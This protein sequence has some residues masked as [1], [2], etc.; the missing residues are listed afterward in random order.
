MNDYLIV[1]NF[2]REDICKEMSRRIF[3]AGQSNQA[4]QD[5]QCPKSPSFYGLF[6]DIQTLS[7]KKIEEA[8]GEELSIT[9]NYCRFYRKGEVLEKHVDREAC[10]ISFTITLDYPISPWPIFMGEGC[11]DGLILHRGDACIYKGCEVIHWRD[12]LNHQD[13]QTQAFFHYVRKGGE[14][15]NHAGDN[16]NRQLVKGMK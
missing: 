11:T 13:W 8:V 5:K 7:L 15:A 6:N 9:Y 1:R 2:F 16:L 12:Q 10:E 4:V 3:A 14:F